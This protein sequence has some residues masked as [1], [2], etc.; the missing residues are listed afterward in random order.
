MNTAK[1]AVLGSKSTLTRIIGNNVRKYRIEAGLTQEELAEMVGIG[2]SF[3][4][5]IECGQKIMSVP[6]LYRIAQ[7]LQISSD[8]LLYE[9][10]DIPP[11]ERVLN[12]I[13]N[14]PR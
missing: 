2:A 4:A 12:I 1:K 8:M 5:R 6:V 14:Y 9:R 7:V 10:I 13:S 3:I 11:M